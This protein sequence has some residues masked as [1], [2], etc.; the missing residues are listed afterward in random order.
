MRQE[1]YFPRALLDTGQERGGSFNLGHA[2]MLL[3]AAGAYW[4]LVLMCMLA[5]ARLLGH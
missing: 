2:I 5:I 3:A 1:D 4:T